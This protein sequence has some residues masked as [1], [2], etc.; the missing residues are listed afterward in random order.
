[1]NPPLDIPSQ[2]GSIEKQ[3]SEKKWE[4]SQRRGA[5]SGYKAAVGSISDGKRGGTAERKL[6]DRIR[7]TE[8]EINELM[9]AIA[10]LEAHSEALKEA[11]RLIER[12]SGD[13]APELRPGSEL[14]RIRDAIRLHKKPMTLDEMLP[15]IEGDAGDLKKRNSLRGSISRYA[16][17]GQIFVKTAPNTFGLIELKHQAEQQPAGTTATSNENLDLGGI[18]EMKPK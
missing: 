4:L 6:D 14:F 9:H 10:G 12:E 15:L 2:L 5:L 3:L 1:M 17:D 7:K 11:Q 18:L 8:A 16:R 13:E